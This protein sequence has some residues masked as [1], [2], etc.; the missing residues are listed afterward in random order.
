MY[1]ICML[2]FNDGETVRDSIN[3]VLELSRSREVEVVVVDNVSTDGSGEFLQKFNDAGSIKLIRTKCSRGKGRQIAFEA[4][5]GTYVLGH[6]DCDDIFNASGIDYLISK[7]HAGFE[8]KAMMTKKIN[9]PEA[10]NI[11]I[12]PRSV[13]EEVG[14][15]RSI[16]WGE[17]WDLWARLA[18]AG[19]YTFLPYPTER[20]PHASIK[21]RTERF[22]GPT[23]GFR[24]RVSKYADSIRIGR[25]VFTPGEHVSPLQRV[26]LA[27]AKAE[28]TVGGSSLSPVLNPDFTEVTVS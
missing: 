9:S 13:L 28:V 12:A 4:S 15:W 17:D 26:A 1:S 19:A 7:Y 24:V 8:G 10:S 3:S 27:V 25:K 11:T 21:V 2:C 16:N 18:A 23:H 20:P 14:G 6:M 5:K 22:G